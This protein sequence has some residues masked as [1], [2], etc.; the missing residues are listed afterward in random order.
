VR[1]CEICF[2]WV[3]GGVE[4]LRFDREV[5]IFILAMGVIGYAEM[6]VA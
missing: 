4:F 5:G 2:G 1:L 3:D 6:D